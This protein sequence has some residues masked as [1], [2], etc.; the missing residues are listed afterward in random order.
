MHSDGM[1]A[2]LAPPLARLARLLAG[3][4]QTVHVVQ[5]LA[6]QQHLLKT[7]QTRDAVLL[8]AGGSGQTRDAVVLEAGGSGLPPYDTWGSGLPRTCLAPTDAL[9]GV[10]MG[11][12]G[13]R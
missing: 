5:R 11:G 10:S 8:E 1:Q 6:K 7:D 13:R 9:R 3:E 4:I 2:S 12:R